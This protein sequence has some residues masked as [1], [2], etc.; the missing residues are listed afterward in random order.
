MLTLNLSSEIEELLAQMA[1]E[2]GRTPE[3]I[4]RRALLD[5]MEDFE[6]AKLADE[7]LRTSDGV[8]FTLEEVMAKYPDIVPTDK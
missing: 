2:T 3:E 5:V 1:R 4:A 8:S 6:D 7:R